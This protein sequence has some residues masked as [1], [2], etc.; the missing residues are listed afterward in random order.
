MAAAVWSIKD[1]ITGDYTLKAKGPGI[2]YGIESLYLGMSY[3]G[4]EIP[5]IKY[6]TVKGYEYTNYIATSDTYERIADVKVCPVDKTTGSSGS[7]YNL[8]FNSLL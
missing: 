6:L 7:A 1:V 4:T 8:H 3:I 5:Y 2:Q